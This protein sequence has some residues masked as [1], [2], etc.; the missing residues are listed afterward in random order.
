M[1]PCGV[2]IV[3]HRRCTSRSVAHRPLPLSRRWRP[4]ADVGDEPID[5]L[6]VGPLR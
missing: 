2:G 4:H 5:W 1:R 6:M 3:P